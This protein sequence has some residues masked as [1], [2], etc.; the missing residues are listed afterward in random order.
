[1]K[2][3]LSTERLGTSRMLYSATGVGNGNT[4]SSSNAMTEK[5]MPLQHW[6]ACCSLSP[7]P[8]PVVSLSVKVTCIACPAWALA[9]EFATG[10]AGGELIDMAGGASCIPDAACTAEGGENTKA[11]AKARMVSAFNKPDVIARE[12]M[13]AIMGMKKNLST[14]PALE[15]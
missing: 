7:L 15:G 8:G 11:N 14:H 9:A 13:C 10:C 6:F 3:I 2:P 4:A 12:D 5:H 1:M